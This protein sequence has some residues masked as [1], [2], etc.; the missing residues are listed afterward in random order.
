MAALFFEMVA[1]SRTWGVPSPKHITKN[2][3]KR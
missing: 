1:A 2:W 3:N